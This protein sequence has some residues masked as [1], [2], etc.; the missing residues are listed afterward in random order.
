MTTVAMICVPNS[1]ASATPPLLLT[2]GYRSLIPSGLYSTLPTR[3]PTRPSTVH[4]ASPSIP[5]GNRTGAPVSPP[6]QPPPLLCWLHHSHRPRPECQLGPPHG[7]HTAPRHAPCRYT[8]PDEGCLDTWLLIRTPWAEQAVTVIPN[9]FIRYHPGCY[10]GGGRIRSRSRSRR[11]K[12]GRTR[13]EQRRT[14]TK[15]RRTRTNI[16]NENENGNEHAKNENAVSE[17]KRKR[18]RERNF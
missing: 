12:M 3:A 17:R 16:L 18:K 2:R 4:G 7:T 13:T 14:R 15:P 9:A 6:P 5:Y 1:L 10:R 11:T 8:R